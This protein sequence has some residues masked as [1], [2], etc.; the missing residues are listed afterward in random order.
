MQPWPEAFIHRMQAQLGTAYPA[1]WA[2]MQ[3][4]PVVSLRRNP[5][6]TAQL[7]Y[8]VYPVPWHPAGYYLDERPDSFAL[9][10]LWHAGAYYVQEASSMAL[11]QAL[12]TSEGPLRILDL[13]AAPGGKSS[14]LASWMPPGSLLIA[15]EVIAS[16]NGILR[17]N[18]ERW[19][20]P[21][22][23]VTQADPA[24]FAPLAGSFDVVVVDAPCSGEGLWRKQPYAVEEWSEEAV[25]HCAARQQRVLAEAAPLVAAG[26]RLIY[27]TCT[28]GTEENDRQ[29][30]SL[31]AA[32]WEVQTLPA[33]EAAGF[34][35]TVSGGYQAYPHLVKGEGF[36]LAV[37][38]RTEACI[39]QQS[40]LGFKPRGLP[41]AWQAWLTLSESYHLWE[42]GRGGWA[43][44]AVHAGFIQELSRSV[45]VTQPGLQLWEQKGKVQRPAH[46][47]AVSIALS[48]RI[49]RLSLPKEMALRY[50]RGEAL[51]VE[52]MDPLPHSPQGWL[53]VAYQGLGLGWAKVAGNRLNNLLP[54]GLRLRS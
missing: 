14:L 45:R 49:S 43:Q 8:T 53:L 9:D 20:M 19:G 11:L 25:R 10:P 4:A 42:D 22:V 6:K 48:P 36:F 50:L 18:L 15:N 37:L 38:R 34:T 41:E 5:A 47:L 51:P 17:E 29:V 40:R 39:N 46:A 28:F 23:V 35:R 24:Q 13:A 1:F 27:S 7:P 32:G 30:T 21:G 31:V 3:Q 52:A 12:P 33:L 44:P 54:T 26:G 16:R 2:A